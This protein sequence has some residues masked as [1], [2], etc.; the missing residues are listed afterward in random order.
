MINSKYPSKI[1]DNCSTQNSLSETTLTIYHPFMSI[2]SPFFIPDESDCP[3]K[4][5]INREYIEKLF[6]CRKYEYEDI[7]SQIKYKNTD[8]FMRGQLCP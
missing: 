5:E 6:L 4:Y 7:F 3:I 8:P 2:R 1:W